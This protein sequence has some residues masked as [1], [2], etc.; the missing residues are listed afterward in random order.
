M[1]VYCH[2]CGFGEELPPEAVPDVMEG[3]YLALCRACRKG[4][5]KLEE[6]TGQRIGE[7]RRS[8]N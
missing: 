6:Q 8:K 7:I 1:K 2:I 5:Q 4:L 3:T